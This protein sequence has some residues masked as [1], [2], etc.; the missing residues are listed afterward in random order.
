MT[1]HTARRSR[2]NRLPLRPARRGVARA[3]AVRS[4]G[5]ASA[6]F[7]T[8]FSDF[9]RP[10]GTAARRTTTPCRGGGGR[11]VPDVFSSLRPRLEFLLLLLFVLFLMESK[12]RGQS[13]REAHIRSNL[14]APLYSLN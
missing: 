3:L 6:M 13:E 1:P 14:S 9:G 12:R 10:M 5:S 8:V 4:F 7:D 2:V 11:E